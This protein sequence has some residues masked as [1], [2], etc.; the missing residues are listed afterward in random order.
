MADLLYARWMRQHRFCLHVLVIK[1]LRHSDC[2]HHEPFVRNCFR[3]AP[4]GSEGHARENEKVIHLSRNPLPA[5]VVN[6]LEA[7]ARTKD[8]LAIGEFVTVCCCDLRLRHRI[9]QRKYDGS[10]TTT[11]L[12]FLNL[13]HGFHNCF[14]EAVRGTTDRTDQNVRLMVLDDRYEVCMIV[15][16]W[17]AN[18]SG[19][20]L[21][22]ILEIPSSSALRF[23][24]H[25]FG[26]RANDG[27]GRNARLT[28]EQH[29]T[30]QIRRTGSM[31]EYAHF[32]ELLDELFTTW[33]LEANTSKHSSCH[34]S[35]CA[36]DVVIVA[37][38]FVPI[39]LEKRKS[40]IGIEVFE[41][42]QALS[43][44]NFSCR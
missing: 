14:V 41:L 19:C 7:R 31:E 15:T 25:A 28:S 33:L 9:R 13:K 39:L 35:C 5:L 3:L 4:V 6:W 18:H 32:S 16:R 21:L 38:K 34:N 8:R 37:E 10:P 24:N 22:K 20:F 26:I 43:A 29:G 36:L 1:R 11:R 27:L 30:S 40:I 44:K 42:E 17:L 2:C 23:P 12:V